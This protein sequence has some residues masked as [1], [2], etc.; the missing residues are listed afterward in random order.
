MKQTL[1]RIFYPVRKLAF[2]FVNYQPVIPGHTIMFKA[3]HIISEQGI[4]GDYLE[5]GVWTGNSLIRGYRALK[6]VSENYQSLA[7][8]RLKENAAQTKK[9]WEDMRFFAFDSFQ[10]LPELDG[11]DREG[12]FFAKG[13]FACTESDVRENLVKGGVPL[14]KVITVPGWY[15]E[16]C[17][18]ETIRK[19]GMK[20]AA[21]V[22]V[23]CDLYESTKTV[24]A[25]VEP[26]LVDGTI[27]IFDDWT[28]YRGNPHLGEQRAFH[29]WKATL[30]DWVF[31]EYQKEG[32]S[33]TSFIASKRVP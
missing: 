19:Y 24:L 20:K 30:T 5:F 17:T 1:N 23:D 32:H 13:Q 9:V 8:Y 3:A 29:E 10:G 15:K 6:T 4:E 25:F 11:I 16:T 14:S 2:R 18:T 33:R 31:S 27:I 12:R 7:P 26:L 28:C 21:I 22:F